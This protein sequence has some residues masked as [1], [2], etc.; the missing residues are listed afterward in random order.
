MYCIQYLLISFIISD[1]VFLENFVSYFLYLTQLCVFQEMQYET[2]VHLIHF[3]LLLFNIQA[4][5]K[6]G[7][8]L[9]IRVTVVYVFV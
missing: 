1:S 8:R 5:A 7:K 3:H 2:M 9:S 4:R 6:V